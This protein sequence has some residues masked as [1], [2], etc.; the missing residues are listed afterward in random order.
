MFF[1]NFLFV[2]ASKCSA[3]SWNME[4]KKNGNV[5][6]WLCKWEMK[7]FCFF[8]FRQTRDIE[9]LMMNSSIHL[10]FQHHFHF[11]VDVCNNL[12]FYHRKHCF[13]FWHQT[14]IFLPLISDVFCFTVKVLLDVRWK[15]FVIVTT[16]MSKY[17]HNM[18]ER[19]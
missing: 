12:A 16:C 15:S 2:L 9:W 5:W 6:I 4:K 7:A 1:P 19:I 3:F 13:K 11:N 14:N 8:C 18:Y 10:M 17:A